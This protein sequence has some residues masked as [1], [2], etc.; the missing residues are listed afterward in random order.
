MSDPGFFTLVV[1]WFT[2]PL[3]WEGSF[4]IPTRLVEHLV[5]SGVSVAIAA[6]VALPLGMYIGHARRLEFLVVS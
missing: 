5:T 1:E 4:G 3:H 6:V 2:D